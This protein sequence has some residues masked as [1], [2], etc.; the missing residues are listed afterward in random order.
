MPIVKK[1]NVQAVDQRKQ[2]LQNL[3]SNIR[4]KRESFQNI[5]VQKGQPVRQ[6]IRQPLPQRIPQR[7]PP[8]APSPPSAPTAGGCSAC[9]GRH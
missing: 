7:I 3:S 8:I 1:A 4:N 5:K 2:M 6:P 9:A